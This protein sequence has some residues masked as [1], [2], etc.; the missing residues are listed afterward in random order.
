[1]RAE[2]G[3]RIAAAAL[4]FAPA[5]AHAQFGGTASDA[6]V[7]IEADTLDVHNEQGMAIYEGRV[8]A[9]Q[10]DTQ[11]RSDRLELYFDRS[12]G[13]AAA[14]PQTGLG[15]MTHAIAIGSV[16]YV[17]PQ[18]I[19]TGDRAYYDVATDTVTMT[20]NVLVKQGC[21]VLSGDEMVMNMTTRDAQVRA[22]PSAPDKPGRVRT[23]LHSGGNEE[24][25]A[26]AAAEGCE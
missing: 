14:T 4:V 2:I 9:I 1:M 24:A 11:L 7:V 25:E 12:E 26:P 16:Y 21:D 17:T 20:G 13:A 3:I 18:Q 6:P 15:D 19:A 23:V 10:D 5:A 8:D 22:A